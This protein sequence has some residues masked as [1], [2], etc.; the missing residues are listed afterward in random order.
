V[1]AVGSLEVGVV[2]LANLPLGR[3]EEEEQEAAKEVNQSKQQYVV[4]RF[5]A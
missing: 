2:V 5:S 3:E 1:K 4:V